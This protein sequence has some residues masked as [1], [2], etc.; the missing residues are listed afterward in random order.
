M[1]AVFKFGECHVWRSIF[2]CKYYIWPVLFWRI[3]GASQNSHNKVLEK[4]KHS[5]VSKTTNWQ[6]DRDASFLCFLFYLFFC[7]IGKH[8][9]SVNA[10]FHQFNLYGWYSRISPCACNF[11]LTISSE[12]Y[13][14]RQPPDLLILRLVYHVSYSSWLDSLNFVRLYFATCARCTL[15]VKFCDCT[16]THIR[17][18]FIQIIE[19]QL[20]NLSEEIT[21]VHYCFYCVTE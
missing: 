12:Y 14:F 16:C 20:Q 9:Y 15:H 13:V 10:D 7:V 5:A 8:G 21:L 19:L 1:F 4:I 18:V 11:N 17:Y 3:H 2:V 6:T